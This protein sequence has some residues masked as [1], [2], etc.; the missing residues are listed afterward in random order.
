MNRAE[1]GSVKKFP[2]F[3]NRNPTTMTD[4]ETIL[5]ANRYEKLRKLNPQQHALLWGDSLFTDTPFD[6][7]VDALPEPFGTKM[8]EEPRTCQT[9]KHWSNNLKKKPKFVATSTGKCKE[10]FE[11][12][13]TFDSELEGYIPHFEFFITR[14]TFG[15][16][17]YEQIKDGL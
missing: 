8:K 2:N 17:E 1:E 14:A 7:L 13:T 11:N 9:C 10:I 5:A 12:L 16:N 4:Q 6:E 3:G 15:C